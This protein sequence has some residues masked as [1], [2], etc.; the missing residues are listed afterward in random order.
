MSTD[1]CKHCKAER[2]LHHFRTH[3][4][5]VGGQQARIGK[6]LEWRETTFEA[7]VNYEEAIR[8]RDQQIELLEKQVEA[9]RKIILRLREIIADLVFRWDLWMNRNVEM[10]RKDWLKARKAVEK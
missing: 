9:N 10:R 2:G 1:I 5:P 7:G 4:C 8:R 3:Q 6:L